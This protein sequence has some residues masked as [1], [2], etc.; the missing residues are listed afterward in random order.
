MNARLMPLNNSNDEHRKD[1]PPVGG[2]HLP[3]DEG[4][5]LFI[6]GDMMVFTMFFGIFLYFR[7]LSPELYSSSQALLSPVYGIVNTIILLTSSW[8]VVAAVSAFRTGQEKVVA[9][10]IGLAALCGITFCVLK[11]F[12][13]DA[14]L[15]KG[16]TPETNEF[17]VFYY[18][19]TGI[20]FVHLVVGVGVLGYGWVKLKLRGLS[21][22]SLEEMES[23]ASY[24][25]MVDL[26]W[27]VI[28]P[29]LYLVP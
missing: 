6:V 10:L 13:Y 14:K 11:Y 23:S 7:G 26:L 17:F 29:L 4:I 16:I 24:W 15:A 8:L 27:I 9:R 21:A 25:H 18:L 5:W 22:L 3:G 19:L 1:A 2:R 20:H 12:E 28:F